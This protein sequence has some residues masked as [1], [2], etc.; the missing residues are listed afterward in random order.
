MKL[1][2]PLL[3]IAL[4]A[5]VV[6]GCTVSRS[7]SDDST[8]AAGEMCVSGRC[9]A[10]HGDGGGMDAGIDAAQGS[11][12]CPNGG[13]TSVSGVVRI[14]AGTL[15]VPGAV[16]YAASGSPEEIPTGVGTGACLRCDAE[17]SHIV[18]MP[19][20]TN[21][22]GT[23]Q[24]NDVT[25]GDDVRI[26]VQIGKWRREVVVPHVESCMNTPLDPEDTRLPRNSSEGH[27]PRFALT[28]GSCDGMECLL[29]KLGI[30]D[31]E[32]TTPAEG[33]RVS[34][35]SDT[36]CTTVPIIGQTCASGR[37][38]FD[39]SLG[40]EPFPDAVAW[41]SSLDNLREYDVVMHSCECSATIDNKSPDALQA[42]HDYADLGGRAF[43][44]HYHYTWLQHSPDPLW[45]GMASWDGSG[46]FDTA[47]GEIDT[48]FDRGM[49]LADWMSLPE[50]GGST[51]HGEI[52]L[53][54][55]RQSLTSVGGAARPW[56]TI[57]SVPAYFSF[58]T[59]VNAI[60]QE[61]CGRVVFSDIHVSAA[62]QAMS[63]PFT[64]GGAPP[65][66]VG[67]TTSLLPQEKA[68]IFLLFDLT[69]CVG[70]PLIF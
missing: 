53:Q 60:E 65:F 50:V 29:R 49:L 21:V 36:V 56:I 59:P 2:L 3:A 17:L 33:G 40:G 22:D 14:P 8:C 58:D 23:F 47:T 67:C 13:T 34:L 16:V 7:C 6:T 31:A 38:R 26:V 41:W 43:L 18:G 11:T 45:T 30:D 5:S 35:F 37:N 19:T 48:S 69:N 70:P 55:A 66:P 57:D 25:P 44:T 54:E 46:Q 68:L 62:D 9:V 64:G 51:S 39:D 15:P 63:N 52:S 4:A 10:G 42:L 1:Y 61:V 28:T 12:L 32:F 24:L 20:H 27:L